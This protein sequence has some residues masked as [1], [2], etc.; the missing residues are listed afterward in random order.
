MDRSQM[1]QVG[2][3]EPGRS[4]G[5]EAALC[6]DV[7]AGRLHSTRT[8]PVMWGGGY[9]RSCSSRAGQKRAAT[10]PWAVGGVR[11]RRRTRH[12]AP[13]RRSTPRSQYRRQPLWWLVGRRWR[14][15]RRSVHPSAPRRGGDRSLPRH[16][17]P[18]LRRRWR[19]GTRRCRRSTGVRFTLT[20]GWAACLAAG[21][22]TTDQARLHRSA[23]TGRG[24]PETTSPCHERQDRGRLAPNTATPR[25]TWTARSRS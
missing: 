14:R 23:C 1:N 9:R 12:R 24:A 2:A 19:A 18:E 10:S 4:D 21:S 11:R 3:P 25:G 22:A 8:R 7:G 15:G 20:A 6:A 17:P 5:R 16:T 13:P